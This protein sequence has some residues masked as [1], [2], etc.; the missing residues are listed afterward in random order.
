MFNKSL[1][2]LE[3]HNQLEEVLVVDLYFWYECYN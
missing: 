1:A 3:N 2:V